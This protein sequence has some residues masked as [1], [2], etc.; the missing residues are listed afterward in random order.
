MM[1]RPSSQRHFYAESIVVYN[2]SL[3]LLVVASNARL[4]NRNL[5]DGLVVAISLDKSHALHDPH[6]AADASKDGVL[7]VEPRGGS[8]RDETTVQKKISSTLSHNSFHAILFGRG[9]T[10]NWLPLVFGPELAM[11][12]IP[13][14]VCFKDGW[15]SSS[16]LAP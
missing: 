8:K 7:S 4:Q 11:L 10:H 3:H 5:I 13:A 16:N 12:K 14:P 1:Q 15:I 2:I 9:I 6:S